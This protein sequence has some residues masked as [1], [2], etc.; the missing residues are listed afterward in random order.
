MFASGQHTHVLT[1]VLTNTHT[2]PYFGNRDC[3]DRMIDSIP[4]NTDGK[5]SAFWG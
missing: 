2:N 1:N 5:E 3:I 4:K